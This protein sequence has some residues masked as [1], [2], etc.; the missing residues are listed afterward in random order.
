MSETPRN[1]VLGLQYLPANDLKANDGNPRR[2]PQAQRETL[3]GVVD[4]LGITGAL[5]AYDSERQGGL[6]LIDGHL[7]KE[8][9]PDQEWPVLVLDLTDTEADALLA[10]HDAVGAMAE[11]DETSMRDLL[12]RTIKEADE[13]LRQS[14]L[15]IAQDQGITVST[16][17]SFSQNPDEAEVPGLPA[18]PIT[19]TGDLWL[20]GRHRLVCGDST[21]PALI[22]RV[23]AGRQIQCV[24]TDPPYGV[25]YVGKTKD[26]LTIDNDG[27]TQAVEIFAR[28][29]AAVKPRMQPGCPF[30]V[31]HPHGPLA[32]QFGQAILDA[33]LL[34]HQTL[35]W[36]KNVMVMGHSDYHY[37]HEPVTY[38][39]LPGEEDYPDEHQPILY[40]W[41]NQART[42]RPWFA[43][44]KETSVF[45]VDRPTAS[46]VHPTMKPVA[47]IEPMVKNSTQPG[48]VVFDGFAGSGSTLLACET[49]G[50]DFRGL[51]LSPAYCDVIVARWEAL[52]GLKAERG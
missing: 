48:W 24:W 51:E 39:W 2:H 43:R 28:H 22:D 27:A 52:T 5:L 29:L 34:F 4:S 46:K 6:T 38:G 17:G 44:R 21:D 49:T 10:A 32:I 26:A 11:Y 47:L 23:L 31:A 8:D 12:E 33:G 18:E 50:R 35:I 14:L 19:R 40:G 15:S 42:K 20:L 16:G 41:K 7:R 1:R 45:A 30:Y 36:S 13:V 3:R 9:Y 37:E 25:E